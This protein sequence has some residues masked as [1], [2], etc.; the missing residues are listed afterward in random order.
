MPYCLKE[1]FPSFWSCSF[2]GGCQSGAFSLHMLFG[3][4][5]GSWTVFST[6]NWGDVQRHIWNI[7][8]EDTTRKTISHS[9]M[10]EKE[11]KLRS[12]PIIHYDEKVICIFDT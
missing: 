2:S 11:L 7:L 1:D 10:L 12:V 3:K 8:A 6:L 9:F 4:K 5:S